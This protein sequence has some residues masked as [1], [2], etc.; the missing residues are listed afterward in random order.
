MA[1][2]T[3][4]RGGRSE[5]RA[6]DSWS[7]WG[8]VVCGVVLLAIGRE[9]RASRRQKDA[10]RVDR[11][12]VAGDDLDCGDAGSGTGRSQPS[13]NG[14]PRSTTRRPRS[15]TAS[16]R[17]TGTVAR[18]VPTPI[19]HP[20]EGARLGTRLRKMAT[21]VIDQES[22]VHMVL[23]LMD[24]V[25]V[26]SHHVIQLADELIERRSK[27]GDEVARGTDANS[28][29]VAERRSVSGDDNGTPPS[30]RRESKPPF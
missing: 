9:E 18:R 1:V 10:R 21:K 15:I 4:R 19:Q 11:E 26:R 16:L 12:V 3:L 13:G 2:S 14:A 25:I 8:W 30:S 27:Q 6:P 17:S 7:R 22:E 5:H 23:E 20:T 29:G 24:H 28:Q